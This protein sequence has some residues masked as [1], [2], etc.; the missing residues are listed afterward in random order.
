MKYRKPSRRVCGQTLIEVLIT[1][2]IM[3]G[4]I[5]AL[6]RFQDYL[7]YD[8]LLTQQKADAMRLASNQIETLKN[9]QVLNNTSGYS[10]YQSI[11]SGNSTSTVNSTTYTITWT[12]T[13]YTN[14]TYKN[15]NV[16]VSWTDRNA[17]PQSVS[18]VTNIAGID[19]GTSGSIM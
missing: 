16:A 14:P 6:I 1:V 4:T 13:S 11:A 7:A 15:V 10:S 8:S 5:V 9:F 2:L 17:S 19:P 12:V 3:A 18:L